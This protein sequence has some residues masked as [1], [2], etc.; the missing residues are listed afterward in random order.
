[1]KVKNE[2]PI[3]YAFV[4]KALRNYNPQTV[5]DIG[6]GK[7]ALPAL[8]QTCVTRVEAMDT[9]AHLVHFPVQPDDI[10]APKRL[11]QPADMI[12]CISVLEHIPNFT[13]AVEN[14]VKLLNPDGHLVLTFPFNHYEFI[15]NAYTLTGQKAPYICAQYCHQNILDWCNLFN[16]EM[17]EKEYW[18]H[19]SGQY[20]TSG[21]R[22]KAELSRSSKL[23]HLACFVLKKKG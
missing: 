22:I 12:T 20:W 1:M 23:H 18:K 21:E 10:T 11:W 6:S 17:V 5:L 3:E 13:A 9:K 8:L 15:P 19:W 14:M 2:R 4:F 7:T 16:L